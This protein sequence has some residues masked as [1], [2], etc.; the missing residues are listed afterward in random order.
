[1]DQEL[2]DALEAVR[3][4]CEAVDDGLRANLLQALQSIRSRLEQDDR[5]PQPPAL[6]HR[7]KNL[8][9]LAVTSPLRPARD[10]AYQA[11]DA[12]IELVWPKLSEEE[13]KRRRK[14]QD[15]T[16]DRSKRSRP[17]EE[18]AAEERAAGRADRARSASVLQP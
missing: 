4:A 17:A 1:M 2:A 6:P 15:S 5:G 3:K 16:R 12:V 10:A 13:K 11:V 18:R 8:G 7:W 9:K 14:E